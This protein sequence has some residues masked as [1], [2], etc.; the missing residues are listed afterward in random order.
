MSHINTNESK[1]I[2]LGSGSI[3]CIEYAGEI[4]S[5]SVIET[6]SN[7]LGHITGG[8]SV[9]YTPTYYN[10]KD[11][12][13]KV[14]KTILTDEEAKLGLG[15]ITWNANTL[16]KLCAN[17]TVTESGGKRT[18]KIGGIENQNVKNYLFRFVNKDAVDGDIRITVVGS[19]Q[20]GIEMT[21]AKDKETAINPEINVA[22]MEDGTLIIFE[23]EILSVDESD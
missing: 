11:D 13:N 20:N 12:L 15:L 1:R 6:E 3:F 5:D 14:R 4:P 21:W 18:L 9:T 10:A 7:R 17:G 16:K 22:A 2:P 23:E 19:N 8:A